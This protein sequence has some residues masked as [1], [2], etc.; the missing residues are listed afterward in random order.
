MTRNTQCGNASSSGRTHR[1]GRTTGEHEPQPNDNATGHQ[2]EAK[3]NTPGQDEAHPEANA[4]EEA[5]I[6]S[7][8]F[9]EKRSTRDASNNGTTPIAQASAFLHPYRPYPGN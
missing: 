6:F 7:I 2:E 3:T 4:E 8:D 9:D 5:S 1:S